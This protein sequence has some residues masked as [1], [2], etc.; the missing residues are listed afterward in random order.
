MN[1]VDTLGEHERSVLIVLNERLSAKAIA[2][3][4]KLKEIEV[5]RALQWLDNKELV[6]LEK[7]NS[8]QIMRDI[9]GEKYVK[10]GLPEKVFLKAIKD[11]KKSPDK[12][13]LEREELQVSIGVLKKQAAI[14]ILQP[15]SFEITKHGKELIDKETLE[16]K[17]LKELPKEFDSLKPE[18]KFAYDKLTARKQLVKIVEKKTLFAVKTEK[19]KKLGKIKQEKLIGRLTQAQ[20]TSGSWKKYKF[21]SYDVNATVPSA[22]AGQR[23]VIYQAIEYIKRIWLDMGFVEMEGTLIQPSFWNFDALFTAQDHPVREIHDTFFIKD[24]M[25]ARLPAKKLVEGIKRVHEDGGDTGSKGWQY[26]WD[27]KKAL[28]NCMRTHTTSLSART[29]GSLSEKDLPA[30]FFSVG[31][32]FR[33]ETIDWGHSMEFFQVEGIVIAKGVTFKHLLG[34]LK[35]YYKKLGY[36]KVRFRPGYFPYTEMSVEPEVFHPKKKVWMELGGAGIF[37]PEVVKPLLGIDVPVLAW[38][39]GM[40]RGILEHLKLGDLRK[41][42]ATNLTGKR[43]G[44]NKCQQ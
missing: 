43:Q 39:Q 22:R 18:E 27:P 40:E 14:N 24:P 19:A 31:R 25:D 17:F 7:E 20:I 4:T 35:I 10:K 26:K 5:T 29:I 1:I 9:N 42:Y 13:P 12:I 38:G 41:L 34:Y 2:Q 3:L 44:W 33:N 32:N 30:K 37:R 36:D 8:K 6:K 28:L 16:E 11:G 23:H 15:L 21:K